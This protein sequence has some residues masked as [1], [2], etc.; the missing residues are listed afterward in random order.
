LTHSY[1]PRQYWAQVAEDFGNFDGSGLAPVLHPN[2]PEWYNR[3]I[4]AMQFRA[5]RKALDCA[6]LSPGSRFLDVGCG[7]G[8]WLRRYEQMGFRATGV[9]ATPLMLS[10]AKQRGTGSALVGGEAFRLPFADSTFDAVSDITVIQHIVPDAQPQALAE[11]LRVIKPGGRLI[12]MELIRGNGTHIFPRPP[13]D[14][15]CGATSAGAKLISWF[16]QEFMLIDRAFVH[17]A[18]WLG[19][20]SKKSESAPVASL[21]YGVVREPKARQFYWKIRHV[22]APLS[23]GMESVTRTF[24][25]G[26]LATHGMFVFSK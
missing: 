24:L 12:L 10:L 15:I 5:I 14:W 8:R 6:E 3:T 18:R 13:E 25:P 11:Y 26:E 20:K 16:G 1:S 17:S 7:T 23:A 9:D 22:T 19:A 2:V 21:G 4:D